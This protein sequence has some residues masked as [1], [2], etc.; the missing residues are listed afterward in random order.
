MFF[1]TFDDNMVQYVGYVDSGGSWHEVNLAEHA[2][3]VSF[4]PET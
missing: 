4:R 1:N 3:L 2:Q